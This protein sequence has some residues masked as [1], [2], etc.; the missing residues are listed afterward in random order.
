M[1]L[2]VVVGALVSFDVLAHFF[3]SDSRGWSAALAERRAD[4]ERWSR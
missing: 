1:E 2:L 4:I 3:G